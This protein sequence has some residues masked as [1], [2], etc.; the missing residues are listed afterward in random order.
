MVSWAVYPQLGSGRPAG[1][2]PAIVQ[3]LLRGQLGFQGVTVTDAI[4]AGALRGYG[5]VPIRAALAARAGMDLI[6]AASQDSAEGA[7][8]AAGLQSAL[9]NGTLTAASADAAVERILSLRQSLRP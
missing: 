1:L 6:L 5:P 3:G 7:Q 8:A 9:A 2:S 4:G